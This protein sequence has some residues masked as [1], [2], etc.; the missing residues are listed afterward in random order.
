MI[1]PFDVAPPAAW[2]AVAALLFTAVYDARTGLVPPVPLALAALALMMSLIDGGATRAASA[3][4]CA[5]LIYIGVW[6]VNELHYHFMGHDALGLGD[7][8]W[9]LVAALAY[10]PIPVLIAWGIGAWLA[11]GWLGLRRTLGR[12]VTHVYFVPF[13]LIGLLVALTATPL[14]A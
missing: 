4:F 12:P 9:S 5:L 14:L 11:L 1:L 6:A 10:G 7:A 3:P 2:F 13:I 8:H